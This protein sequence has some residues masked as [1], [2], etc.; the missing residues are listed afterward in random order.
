MGDGQYNPFDSG[1]YTSDELRGFGFKSIGDNV[2]IAKSCTVIGLQNI[3]IGHDVRVDG[4]VTISAYSGYAIIENYIH[5]GT[6]C[7]LNCSGGIVMSDFSGLSQGVKIY[8]ST[9][10]YS[11]KSLTNPTVPKKYLN[12]KSAQVSLGRHVIIGSGSVI[13]PGVAIGEGSA[14]GALSLVTKSLDEWSVYFGSPAKRL[15]SRSRQLLLQEDMLK[16]EMK[17]GV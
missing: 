15:K 11:G 13:M 14:V 3:S 8:S 5:I 16:N 6:G 1:Y 9:D 4:H 12:V 7:Y 2:K 10:D 17:H